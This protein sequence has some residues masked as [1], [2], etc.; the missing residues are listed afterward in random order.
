MDLTYAN[1]LSL[2]PALRKVTPLR[3]SVY[4]PVF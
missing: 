3:T 4:Y 2:S 1:G